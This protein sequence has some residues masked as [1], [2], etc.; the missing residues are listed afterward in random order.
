MVLTI[1]FL[2]CFSSILFTLCVLCPCIMPNTIRSGFVIS[3]WRLIFNCFCSDCTP[4]ASEA[5]LFGL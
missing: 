5:L 1:H 2:I 4:A 3:F